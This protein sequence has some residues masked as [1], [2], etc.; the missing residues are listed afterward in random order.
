MGSLCIENTFTNNCTNLI[1]P[2]LSLA[3]ALACWNWSI[4][5]ARVESWKL[6]CSSSAW[7]WL[8][9]S[10]RSW[11]SAEFV[12]L[13]LDR[14]EGLDHNETAGNGTRI[15][16]RNVVSFRYT[17]EVP[18]FEFSDPLVKLIFILFKVSQVSLFTMKTS[19]NQEKWKT[20]STE[21]V[22]HKV[23]Y[24]PSYGVVIVHLGGF[25]ISVARL[26]SVLQLS[27][28]WLQLL[29]PLCHTLQ[30]ILQLSQYPVGLLNFSLQTSKTQNRHIAHYCESNII[31]FSLSIFFNK[32]TRAAGCAQPNRA[33]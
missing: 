9:F 6:S 23:S 7:M 15:M 31:R 1:L 27:T 22:A 12:W 24:F 33:L 28:L 19:L 11:V 5:W 30:L 14:E 20:K 29:H 13:M 10:T 16:L 21:N 18:V 4:C 2:S 8:I 17:F 32:I 25:E 26:C 3:A